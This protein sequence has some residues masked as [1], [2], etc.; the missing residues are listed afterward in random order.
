MFPLKNWTNLTPF[1]DIHKYIRKINIQR[2]LITSP[3]RNLSHIVPSRTVYAGLSNPSLFNPPVPTASAIKVFR[4]LVLNDLHKLPLKKTFNHSSGNAGLR[5]LCDSRDLVIR[6]VD[7]GGGIV[8]FDNA[9]YQQE[10]CR[11]LSDHEIYSELPNNPTSKY[12]RDLSDFIVKGFD[13]QIKK[14][15]KAY[16]IPLA[17]RIPTI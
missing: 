4:E 15:E 16:L 2:Y 12:K 3:Y 13:E 17:P 8:I 5:S 7:K 14:K 9:D 6:P 1:I 10:M 11:I